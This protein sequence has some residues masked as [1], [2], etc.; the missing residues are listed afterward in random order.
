[1]PAVLIIDDSTTNRRIYSELARQL[2]PNVYVEMF[3][4][5]AEALEW[6]VEHRADL[7]ITDYK[8]PKMNGA[9]L[10]RAVRALP[11]LRDVPIIV[12]TAYD[13]RKFRVASLE[14]GATD[15][16]LSPVDH[17]EFLA[18][19]RNLLK[20][21]RQHLLLADRA[22]QLEI[23]LTAKDQLL[24]ASREALAQVID[25]VP[26]F[27][28]ASDLDGRCVL[29]NVQQAASIGKVP[30]DLVGQPIE[31]LIG[32]ERGLVSRQLD[33]IVLRTGK[34]I[35][36][37]EEEVVTP[38]GDHYIYLTNKA[39][40]HDGAGRISGILTTSIDVTQR[41][42]IE[43][44][45][46]YLANHDSLTG[47]PNRLLLRD[48]LRRELARGRRG[49]Q[50][51]ALHFIDLD[52]FK[53]IN[54][55]HGHHRGDQ[56]L[57][58]VAESLTRLLGPGL[59]VA[60]LGGDEFAVLQPDI[61][62]PEDA[63]RLAVTILRMLIGEDENSSSPRIGASIG[64]TVAPLDG[65]DPDDL[66]RNSDQAMYLAK[67]VGG[68]TVRFFAADMAP[69]ASQR[70]QMESDMRDALKRREFL[71]HYQPLVDLRSG[72]VIGTEALL[73]W[74]HPQHGLLA[75][76]AFLSLAEESG[77]IVPINEWVLREACRQGTVWRQAGLG[78]L[79]MAV[80]LSPVQFRRQK[81]GELVRS[82][83][84]ESGFAPEL[85]DL[86]LTE[87]ILIDYNETVSEQMR[88]LRSLGVSL[89]V[90]DFGTGYSS[91][92]YIRNFPLQR[93]KIDRSFVKDLAIDPRALAIVRTIIELGHN[94]NLK[95]L[96]EGVEEASQLQTLRAEGC[97]E[98][99][100]YYFSRPVP[101]DMFVQWL[102]HR[103][104]GTNPTP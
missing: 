10:V 6:L 69:L 1:M 102:S 77:L 92:N 71:L 52:R 96:A 8:M 37:R 45:L 42:Q 60:R 21:R 81:V 74:A 22:E 91:L 51:F 5:G 3:E 87:G 30:N 99:Q 72:D 58:D 89:S 25:T 34:A 78:D 70:A 4:N 35:A 56:L 97:D 17:V 32:E 2:E 18:R 23:N 46:E 55:A 47:L 84:E 29:V 53:A 94:L 7:I 44:R 82:V 13:D 39:P 67:S 76:G 80:N 50:S 59:T 64:I 15:F 33:Q 31:S 49:N 48:H 79:R 16:L 11:H 104:G 12:V 63:E 90:D 14:A 28:S 65:A 57:Q 93:L 83:I 36:P 19:S 9:E 40:L 98:V 86:E 100:G 68:N 66:L 38:G 101:A 103:E 20:L 41:R 54:D 85:L 95:V 24:R 43:L 61:N 88:L 75:P 62:G 73:R 26:A 27:I